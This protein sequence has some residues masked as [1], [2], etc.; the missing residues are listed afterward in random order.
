[1]KFSAQKIGEEP[2]S[3]IK[4]QILQGR[5]R[6]REL[7]NNGKWWFFEKINKIKTC[8]LKKGTNYKIYLIIFKL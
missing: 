1:M 6:K 7:M 2:K 8:Y 5:K 3:N 4:K